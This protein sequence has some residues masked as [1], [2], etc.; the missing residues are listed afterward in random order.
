MDR[1]VILFLGIQNTHQL[2][3]NPDNS[4]QN[5]YC[6]ILSYTKKISLPSSFSQLKDKDI[7]Q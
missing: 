1:F 6:T 2:L 3:Q 5:F 7:H 4:L